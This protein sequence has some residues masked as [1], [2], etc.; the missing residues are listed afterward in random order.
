MTRYALVIGI[1]IY[2]GPGFSNLDKPAE[3]AEAIAQILDA[4]GDFTEVKRLPSRWNAE[5]DAYEISQN[6]LTGSELEKG[7]A[8][9]SEVRTQQEQERSL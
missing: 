1:Q 9:A 5:K 4:H 2:D 3:D 7:I 6:H 8:I